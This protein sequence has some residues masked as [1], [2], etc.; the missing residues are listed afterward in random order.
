M[1]HLKISAFDQRGKLCMRMMFGLV[2]L[3]VVLAIVGILA[4]KQ[5]GAV[6]STKLPDAASTAGAAGPASPAAG[7]VVPAPDPQASVKAQSQQMQDQVKK[8]MDA[9]LQQPRPVQDEK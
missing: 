9:A 8:A 4:K 6:T 1:Y 5:L 7:V 2:G 3:V